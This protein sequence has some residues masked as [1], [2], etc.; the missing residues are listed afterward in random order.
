M[1]KDNFDAFTPSELNFNDLINVAAG[2]YTPEI[3]YQQ[4]NMDRANDN[5]NSSEFNDEEVIFKDNMASKSMKAESH[6]QSIKE[7]EEFL[8]LA[9]TKKEQKYKNVNIRRKEEIKDK[10]DKISKLVNISIYDKKLHN[11]L[12][13]Q[14]NKEIMLFTDENYRYPK[15]SLER[16]NMI[17]ANKENKSKN[18]MIKLEQ[19]I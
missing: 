6:D 4:L 18:E 7:V 17:N 13:N 8:R 10:M 12:R 1:P 14:I 9:L 15:S 16:S 2:R 19:L 11:E 5:L 3:V